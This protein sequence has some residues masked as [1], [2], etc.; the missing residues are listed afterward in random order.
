M[1]IIVVFGMALGLLGNALHPAG[2]PLLTSVHAL[3]DSGQCTAPGPT[4]APSLAA[5]VSIAPA[6]ARA[7]RGQPGV[8]FG[9][10]RQARDYARGHIAGAVHL[11]C[12]GLLGQEALARIPGSARLVLYDQDGRSL[13]LPT[14]A[15]TAAIRGVREVYVLAGGYDAWL[16]AGLEGESGTCESCADH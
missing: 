7:L 6:E 9:D 13:E 10:L 16:R 15:A 5:P 2:I 11:P 14:A 12:H 8:V 4:A 3:A 1:A